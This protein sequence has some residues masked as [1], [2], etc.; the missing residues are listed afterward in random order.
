MPPSPPTEPLGATPGHKR[1]NRC[2]WT[3]AQ[4]AAAPRRCWRQLE[5]SPRGW[6][7]PPPCWPSPRHP[8]P[9]LPR[10]RRPAAVAA[11]GQRAVPGRH[12]HPVRCHY[13]DHAGRGPH[14][15]GPRRSDA[16][17]RTRP[18]AHS[19]HFA[20]PLQRMSTE[21]SRSSTGTCHAPVHEDS[22]PVA[23]ESDSPRACGGAD[24]W[25]SHP[26]RSSSTIRQAGASPL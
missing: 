3:P 24:T 26:P 5:S 8:S 17:A 25:A 13:P 6:R 12:G 10:C 16:R 11:V 22:K 15:P 9:R 7:W 21:T 18:S 19:C 23:V 2:W 4:S 1:R 14:V 20:G